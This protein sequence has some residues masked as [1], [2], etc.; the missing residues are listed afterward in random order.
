[1]AASLGLPG[2]VG[3]RVSVD[4]C[5]DKGS[6]SETSRGYIVMPGIFKS[7]TVRPHSLNQLSM[8]R[9]LLPYIRLINI[10]LQLKLNSIS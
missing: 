4:K 7:G 8:K 10:H 5:Q 3:V 6:L 1:M 9:K 2:D